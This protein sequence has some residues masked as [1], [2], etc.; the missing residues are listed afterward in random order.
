MLNM[1]KM[2]LYRMFRSKSLYVIWAVMAVAIIFNTAMSKEQYDLVQEQAGSYEEFVTNVD[3][4]EEKINIGMSVYIPMQP[5]ENITVFDVLFASLQPKFIALFL[6][7]FAVIFSSA[8][9]NSGYIK[10]IG[11]QVKNREKLIGSKAIALIIFTIV[12]MAIAVGLQIIANS[13]FFGYLELGN[14]SDLV[15][16]LLV[17]TV[18]HIALVLIGM[19]LSIVL[20]SN[21]VSMIIVVCLCM[22]LSMVI[23]A[24]INTWIQNIGIKDINIIDYTVTGKISML[25]MVPANQDCVSA[26]MVAVVFGVVVTALT[27]LV[28]KR[29]DI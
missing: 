6:V 24:G 16:Y 1:I 19:A 25:P 13:L 18:L 28:F 22:N 4:T 27:G 9:L 17:Q 5:G 20:K 2:E 7:I 23:Y 3:E 29:R 21:L 26:I 15:K 8:D 11:G 10:N 14:V 12:S